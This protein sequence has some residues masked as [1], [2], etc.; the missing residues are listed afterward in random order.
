MSIIDETKEA[1]GNIENFVKHR[2][3]SKNKNAIYVAKSRF[4]KNPKLHWAENVII[5]VKLH[6][7]KILK[8]D[9]DVDDFV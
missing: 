9:I 8:I 4:L 7:K 1:F 2:T 3:Q 6:L 5:K